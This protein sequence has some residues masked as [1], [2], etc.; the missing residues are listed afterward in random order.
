[1]NNDPVCAKCKHLKSKHEIIREVLRDTGVT[2]RLAWKCPDREPPFEEL[3]E[4]GTP[5]Q[6]LTEQARKAYENLRIIFDPTPEEE[7]DITKNDG[8]F[9]H[10]SMDLRWRRASDAYDIL[11]KLF[12]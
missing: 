6:I 12:I 11:E 2:N 9:H 1:M 4:V 3:L 7:A 10:P 5:L 8:I